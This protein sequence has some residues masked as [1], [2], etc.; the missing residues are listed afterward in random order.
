MFNV[1]SGVFQG[2]HLTQLLFNIYVNDINF[3]NLNILLFAYDINLFRIIKSQ[4]DTKLLQN[5]LANL[6]N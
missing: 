6:S 3:V 4:R 1:T 5:E 2:S